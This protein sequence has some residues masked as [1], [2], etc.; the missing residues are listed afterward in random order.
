[1]GLK[2]D[3][4]YTGKVRE[5]SDLIESNSGS[6]GFQV[7]LECEDGYTDYTIWITPKNRERAER[8]FQTLG[9]SKEKLT[10]DR[11]LQNGV[12]RDIA[13][14]PLKFWTVEETYKDKTRVKVAGIGRANSGG[15]AKSAAAIFGGKDADSPGT[16]ITDDDI[17]F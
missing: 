16:P 4:K 17:P 15:A 10:D 2:A 6:L 8:D 14:R 9:V 13:G 5:G 3:T 7:M 11:Y 1:M 12:G